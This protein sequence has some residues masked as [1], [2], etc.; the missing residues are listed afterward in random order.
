MKSSFTHTHTH[1]LR[2]HYITI[3]VCIHQHHH[4]SSFINRK[5]KREAGIKK[6][7]NVTI[8]CKQMIF[9][10]NV[11]RSSS[12]IARGFY[13]ASYLFKRLTRFLWWKQALSQNHKFIVRSTRH[14]TR[15][16]IHF[17]I[18]KM[19]FHLSSL[20]FIPFVVFS[21]NLKKKTILFLKIL[22]SSAYLWSEQWRVAFEKWSKNGANGWSIFNSVADLL[23]ECTILI[24]I[25][26]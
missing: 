16:P 19:D 11:I 6:S 22:I 5:R 2:W 13:F 23:Q 10:V 7:G 21:W 20:Y 25:V 1:T 8:V 24:A 15:I 14:E 4:H 9:Y 18:N 26:R 17:W 12:L 3:T